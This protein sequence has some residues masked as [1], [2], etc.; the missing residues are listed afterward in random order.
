MISIRALAPGDAADV[1]SLNASA[2]PNVARLDAA[3]LSRLLGLSRDHLVATER[4]AI[5]GYA[6]TFYSEHAYDGE[7]FLEL[8]SLIARPFVYI[9]QVVVDR[10]ARRTGIGRDLYGAIEKAALA[11]GAG[12]LCC[13]V[14]TWPP[15]PDSLAFHARLGFGTIGSLATRD[16]REVHL[17]R[18]RLGAAG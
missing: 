18:K 4:E 7:E 10:A 15:N 13:E 8:R 11:R 5:R 3:E 17:L 12:S 16:G 9:D 14:N 2:T 6:L 1:L